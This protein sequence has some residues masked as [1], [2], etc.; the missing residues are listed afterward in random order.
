VDDAYDAKF[1]S[2]NWGEDEAKRLNDQILSLY[3][4][5]EPLI[6]N[7][8]RIVSPALMYRGH[9]RDWREGLQ[10]GLAR[11]WEIMR[12]AH[13]KAW[14]NAVH[15]YGDDGTQYDTMERVR[16]G[17][18]V[19]QMFANR[20]VWLGEVNCNKGTDAQQMLFLVRLLSLLYWQDPRHGAWGPWTGSG[21]RVWGFVPFACNGDTR[22]WGSPNHLISDKIAYELL[23]R[24]MA[25]ERFYFW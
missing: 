22:G 10:P 24:F 9:Y 23:G 17:L 19:H 16:V 7:G 25:G 4:E 5:W 8:L 11:W 14:S 18:W 13:N 15:L 6:K 12:P 20:P 1:G 21:E 3:E 2:P